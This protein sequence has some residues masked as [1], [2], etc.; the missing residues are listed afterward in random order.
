MGDL[1]VVWRGGGGGRAQ[2]GGLAGGFLGPGQGPVGTPGP[3]RSS[4]ERGQEGVQHK[5][6]I[7]WD[8]RKAIG[9]IREG[10]RIRVRGS[11][12]PNFV[13]YGAQAP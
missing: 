5:D 10:V 11:K 12:A 2:G 8:G 6:D 1:V 4:I 3:G 9:G 13:K 7:L